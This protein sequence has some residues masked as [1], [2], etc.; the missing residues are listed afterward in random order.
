MQQPPSRWDYVLEG[1]VTVLL[2]FLPF[3]FGG[4]DEIGPDPTITLISGWSHEIFVGL[5]A[6]MALV[7][8]ARQLFQRD[9]RFVW[10][11][12]Y[13]PIVL[14]ILLAVLQLAQ[15]PDRLVNAI[16]PQTLRTK[17]GLLSDLPNAPS[18]LHSLTL[19]FYAQATR[20]DLRK[21]LAVSTVFV[22]VV[23][24]YRRS[25]Q[26]KRL[27]L[28]ISIIGI[29]IAGLA[30]WQNAFGG[31][32]I[33][34]LVPAIHP[35]SGPFLNHSHFGQFMNLSIGAMLGL[36]LVRIDE[37]TEGSETFD[38]SVQLLRHARLNSV[39]MLG[40]MI[41]L[42]AATIFF[43]LTRGGVGVSAA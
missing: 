12:A 38:D 36:L 17:S 1:L 27:L 30:L 22:V 40:V 37:I 28:T 31:R 11:W 6:L 9:S 19:T 24:V 35:N 18:L 7:L 4:R 26:I 3:A 8:A 2:A 25:W 15:L 33:Y 34:G 32:M 14:F 23:N 39:F 13:L 16:S 5:A 10:S 41:L 21:L 20:L 29:G 42:S 43:S